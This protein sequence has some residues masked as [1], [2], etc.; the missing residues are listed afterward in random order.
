[1]VRLPYAEPLELFSRLCWERPM[2]VFLPVS[3]AQAST[4]FENAY[5]LWVAWRQGQDPSHAVRE[6]HKAA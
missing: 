2:G 6:H 5:A 3:A 1:V 4:E